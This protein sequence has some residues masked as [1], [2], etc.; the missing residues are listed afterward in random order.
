MYSEKLSLKAKRRQHNPSDHN[1]WNKGIPR[2]RSVATL[3]KRVSIIKRIPANP[4]A[5]IEVPPVNPAPVS[6]AQDRNAASPYFGYRHRWISI[7]STNLPPRRVSIKRSTSKHPATRLCSERPF[8]ARSSI[9]SILR[10][11][12]KRLRAAVKAPRR[13]ASR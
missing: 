2:T 11:Q 13:A 5:K 6:S 7:S 9:G 8:R 10:L 3:F 1:Q 12:V 4:P